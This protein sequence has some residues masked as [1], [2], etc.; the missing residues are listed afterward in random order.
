MK[1]VRKKESFYGYVVRMSGMLSLLTLS[2]MI[3]SLINNL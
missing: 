3:E 2:G 1:Q